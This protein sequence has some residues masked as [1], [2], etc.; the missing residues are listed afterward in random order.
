[1]ESFL[2]LGYLL[3]HSQNDLVSSHLIALSKEVHD[4]GKLAV[5]YTE[6]DRYR[7]L[8]VRI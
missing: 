8:E 4:T 6:K 5:F 3:L 7:N 2:P 1:M